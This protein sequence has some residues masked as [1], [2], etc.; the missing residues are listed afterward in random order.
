MK[1]FK[2]LLMSQR[3]PSR[4]MARL[5]KARTLP[6]WFRNSSS[7]VCMQLSIILRWPGSA[8]KRVYS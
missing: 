8:D 6:M 5:A 3:S 4:F 2:M 7:R 1:G